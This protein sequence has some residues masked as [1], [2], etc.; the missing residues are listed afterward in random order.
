MPLSPSRLNC[1]YLT[2]EDIKPF[3]ECYDAH[4]EMEVQNVGKSVNGIDIPVIRFGNGSFKIL[5]WSQMHGNESTTTKMILDICQEVYERKINLSDWT[6]ILKEITLV[7]VPMLNPDGSKAYTRENANDVD[8]NRDA[9]GLTQPESLVLKGLFDKE[10][11]NLCLNLHGQR[12]IYGIK[13]T[14]M[15]AAI[16]FLA[17]SPDL[18]KTITLARLEAMRL[19]SGMNQLLQK[20]IPGQIGRYDDTFNENCVGDTFTSLGCPTILFEAGQLGLDYNRNNTRALL[21]EALFRLLRHIAGVESF[22][23][24]TSDDYIRIPQIEVLLNDLLINSVPFDE[25]IGVVNVKAHYKEVLKDNKICFIP[26]LVEFGKDVTGI[27]HQIIEA[28]DTRADDST[29]NSVII[30]DSIEEYL[31]KNFSR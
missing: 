16:S 3:L 26:E 10:K 8:L 23:E 20:Q 29:T 1:R 14:G 18:T 4:C 28:Q 6:V 5:C 24:Y 15:S 9:Q 25:P 31:L 2:I 22:N 21:K 27:T 13:E 7:I 17:P 12:S 19:I 11:P 30:T